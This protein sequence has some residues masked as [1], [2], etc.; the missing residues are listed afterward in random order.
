VG[1]KQLR[2]NLIREVMI[3]AML[4]DYEEITDIDL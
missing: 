2:D 1:F 4:S 3:D